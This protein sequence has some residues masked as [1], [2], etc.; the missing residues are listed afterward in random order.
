V[1]V[2]Y[3]LIWYCAQSDVSFHHVT[4]GRSLCLADSVCGGAGN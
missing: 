3:L 4:G 2:V 1:Q